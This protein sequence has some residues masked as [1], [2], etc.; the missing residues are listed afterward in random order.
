M[1]NFLTKLFTPIVGLYPNVFF[2]ILKRKHPEIVVNRFEVGNT[3]DL[4]ECSKQT[5]QISRFEDLSFLFWSSPLNRGILRQDFDEAAALYR[6]ISQLKNPRGVEIGRY[7]G[8][9]TIL[10][11]AAVGAMGRLI[12]IDIDP[13]D[14]ENLSSFLSCHGLLERVDLIRGNANDFHIDDGE[15]FD[16]VLIDG[17]HSYEGAKRDH[18]RWGGR[19]KTDGY[20]IHHDM[21]A[22]RSYA[23]QHKALA[24]LKK[25]ILQVQAQEVRVIEESG[26]MCFFQRI[27]A[28][29][30][31]I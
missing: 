21:S 10:L 2:G 29:W 20:I 17:D 22:N 19:V 27:G 31:P 30:T 15:Y 16:F 28:G 9:S 5:T 4:A 3:Y 18:N 1:T 24:R 8:G 25:D 23:S 26:S 11:A 12:S 14:D 6:R 13:Q 7:R